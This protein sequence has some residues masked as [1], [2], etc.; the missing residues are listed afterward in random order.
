MRAEDLRVARRGEVGASASPAFVFAAAPLALLRERVLEPG[1]VR[2]DAVLG[3]ELDRQVDREAVR[4]VEPERDRARQHRRVGRQR[5]RLAADDALLGG[6]RD[7]RLLE[8]AHAGL[9]GAVELALLALDD[10][11]DL[12]AALG[13]VRVRVRHR[14]DHD[15]G[16]LAQERLV[17]A[18]QA[19]VADGAA[20]DPAQD[21]AAALVGRAARRRRRGT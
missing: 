4:V 3:R 18:E 16:R 8:L 2:P 14:V 6:Q 9:E 13:E 11:E 12:V 7:Q 1:E 10:A 20:H 5:L 15:L 21:V 19:P 17:A